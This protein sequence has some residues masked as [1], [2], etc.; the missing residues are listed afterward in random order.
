MA[1]FPFLGAR[2][3]GAQ[4][5]FTIQSEHASRIELCLF[6]PDETEE[7]PIRLKKGKENIW[8]ITL[9]KIEPGQKYGYRA[10]GEYNPSRGLFFNPSKLAVDPYAFAVSKTM[11]N[12]TSPLLDIE[13]RQDSAPIMPK[14]VVVD[15]NQVFDNDKYPYLQARPGFA[16]GKNIIYETHIKNFSKLNFH[17]PEDKRGKLAGLAD[18]WSVRYFKRLGVN[19]IELMP[20]GPTCCGRQIPESEGKTDSWGYNPYCYFAVD[21]R[22]GNL[23]DL[24]SAINELHKAGIKV[25]I[26]A[27]FNHT[28]EHA[29]T[30]ERNQSL[31]FKLLDSPNYYR[32]EGNNQGRFM[33]TTGCDNNFNL[34]S[35]AGHGIL[36]NYLLLMNKLGVDGIRWDL[37][38]DNALDNFGCFQENGAFIQELRFASKQLNMEMY[39]EP[40]SAMGGNFSGRFASLVPGVK[41]WSD[42]RKNFVGEFFSSRNGLLG[43]FGNQVAGSSNINPHENASAVIGTG[44]SHDGFSLLGAYQHPKN[45]FPN[46]EQ[47]RDGSPDIYAK[48]Y[49]SD[50]LYRRANSDIAFNILSKGIPLLR[51][52]DERGYSDPNNNPYCI[53]DKS[54]WLN[55]DNLEEKKKQLFLNICR[56]NAF[57]QRHPVFTDLQLFDGKIVEGTGAKDITWIRPDGKE[58]ET[59]DWN[60]GY[61]KTGAYM[62]NGA[63]GKGR[64]NDDDFLILVS[65]DNY[66]TVDYKLPSPP[67]GGKWQLVFDTAQGEFAKQVQIHSPGSSYSLKPYSY[68]ILTRKNNKT[69]VNYNKL[70]TFAARKSGKTL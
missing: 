23:E 59:A 15:L 6:S 41:E 4:T 31:S 61:A 5:T 39:V 46:G 18:E 34:D 70:V 66:H 50:E 45:T 8:S 53:D 47:G 7:T 13:N 65:G 19:N 56:L 67:G 37:G 29:A 57:R 21:P 48:S 62:L 12:W 42:S 3:H 11:D 58:M 40:W 36:H 64:P 2:Y 27:V 9:P 51:N 26:D 63:A 24:A 55:W 38:G 69:R 54:V 10:Y 32:P 30:G 16:A 28:G 52:G 1:E 68:V 60:C 43:Q 44:R 25:T 20:I 17:L 35:P 33:N 14:S 49:N 22:Y